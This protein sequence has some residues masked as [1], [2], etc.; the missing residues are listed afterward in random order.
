MYTIGIDIGGTNLRIGLVDKT[1]RL[2]CFEKFP[3]ADILKDD[4]PKR[5][6]DFIRQYIHKNGVEGNITAVCTAFP[7]AI[8][9]TRSIVLNAPNISG[10]NGVNVKSV[11]SGEL[12]IP[13]YVEKD[14][15][16]LLLYDLHQYALSQSGITIA[17]Y[18]G[19]GLGNAIYI[20]GEFLTGNNGVAGELGHIPMWDCEDICACGN[21]GCVETYIGGKHLNKLCESEFPQIDIVEIF[22]N[23]REHPLLLQY[24]KRLAMVIAT[25]INILDPEIVII[26]GGVVSM[27]DFP[28]DLLIQ[29]IRHYARK[30]LPESNLKFIISEN[31]GKNGVIGAGIHA[32]KQNTRN[33][34][35]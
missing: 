17:I 22:K 23:H 25:E 12:G 7:A 15:N 16:A 33:L 4:A 29:N 34:A 9:K 10:F 32:W 21:E 20:D 24:I 14:V 19:T 30:P 6:A 31:T 18:A 1:I 5:L 8:D 26:G 27:P 2:S 35:D 11:L 13:V 3:Q 28:I